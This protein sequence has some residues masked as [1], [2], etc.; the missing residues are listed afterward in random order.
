MIELSHE[1]TVS[2]SKT[3]GLLYLVALSIGITIYACWPSNKDKFDR[4][5]QDILNDEDGPWQ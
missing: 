1:A 5:A 2:F 3:F 4:T